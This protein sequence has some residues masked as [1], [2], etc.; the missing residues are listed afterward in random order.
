MLIH[1]SRLLILGS[2]V[3]LLGACAPD[4]GNVA[5]SDS[6]ESSASDSDDDIDVSVEFVDRTQAGAAAFALAGATAYSL[7]VNGC[8][9]AFSTTIDENNS[10]LRILK[11][12]KN[13]EAKL[14]ELTVSGITYDGVTDTANVTPFVNYQA[15]ATAVFRSML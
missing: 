11:F 3:S 6:P 8:A 13:C 2:V 12:D 4:L 14:Q 1:T 10:A 5:K 7:D 15:G 9:S